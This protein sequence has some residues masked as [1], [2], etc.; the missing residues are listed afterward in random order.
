METFEI[1]SFWKIAFRVDG[2]KLNHL[3]YAIALSL[4]Q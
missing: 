2:W 4:V 1:A 3:E